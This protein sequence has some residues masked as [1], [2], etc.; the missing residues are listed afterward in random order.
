MRTSNPFSSSSILVIE[1]SNGHKFGA[2]IA[3]Q[4]KDKK[5]FQGNGSSW[6]FTYH[7]T[8]DLQLWQ[9]TGNNEMYQ[10]S[11]QDGIII[12]SSP[13]AEFFPAIAVTHN[14]S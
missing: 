1:D 11:D 7:D 2:F 4:M 8:E 6:V 12:G 5:G 10:H 13:K 9:A 3:E 14:F